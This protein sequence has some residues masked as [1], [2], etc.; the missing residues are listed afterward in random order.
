[1]PEVGDLRTCFHGH[2]AGRIADTLGRFG[3]QQVLAPN[4]LDLND[5]LTSMDKLVSLPTQP[6]GSGERI[7]AASGRQDGHRIAP[8]EGFPLGASVE[9][10]GSASVF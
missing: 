7:R 9:L 4:V 5:I 6:L 1:V 3:A 8:R 10:T 2:E